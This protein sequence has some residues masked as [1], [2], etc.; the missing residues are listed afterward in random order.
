MAT[1]HPSHGGDEGCEIQ[2]AFLSGALK[3]QRRFGSKT[4][5]VG[6]GAGV[7]GASGGRSEPLPIS[8]RRYFE[9]TVAFLYSILL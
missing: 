4:G 5:G 9:G 6:G 3:P 7:G 1:Y 2:R 8:R